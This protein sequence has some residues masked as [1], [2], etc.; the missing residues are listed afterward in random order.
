MPK[1]KQID[2]LGQI[3]LIVLI[4]FLVNVFFH[5]DLIR[6]FHNISVFPRDICK[7]AMISSVGLYEYLRMPLGLKNA[8]ATFQCFINSIFCDLPFVFSYIDDIIVYS[9]SPEEHTNHFKVILLHLNKLGLSL[10][11]PK[12]K[13]FVEEVDFLGHMISPK[14]FKPTVKRIEFFKMMEQ[15]LII[16]APRNVPGLWNFYRRFS[17]SASDHLAPLN[18]ILKSHTRKNDKTVISWFDNLVDF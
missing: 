2:I 12:S 8:P 3:Y 7:T 9:S 18:D 17:R 14:G 5:I 10:N 6:A 15:P 4:I 16:G 1:L 13:C 11:L